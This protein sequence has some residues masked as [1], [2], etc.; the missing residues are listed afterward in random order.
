MGSLRR[1]VGLA[2]FVAF[3]VSAFGVSAGAQISSFPALQIGAQAPTFSR[4]DLAGKPIDLHAYRGK[5][6]LL[7]FWASWCAPCLL[8]I[9]RLITL[10]KR[11]G[12]QG[13][14]VIGVSMDD[15]AAP[16]VKLARRVAFNYPV[17]LGDAKLGMRYGG[18]YGLPVR[19]LIA[20]D[21][22]ILRIWKGDLAPTLLETT[23]KSVVAGPLAR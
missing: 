2:A 20:R 22:S 15:S 17:L 13:L 6:V 3:A 23:L 9:P 16:V 4:L 12:S 5:V 7:D 10:Q 8:E 18:I 11:L 1:R 21:G 19:I 14:Q